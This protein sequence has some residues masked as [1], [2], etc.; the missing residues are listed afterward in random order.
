MGNPKPRI[1]VSKCL[2][3]ASC[4]YNGQTVPSAII[5]KLGRHVQ[6]IPVCPEVEIGLN[7]PREP[8]RIARDDSGMR[9]VGSV[10]G[11]DVTEKMLTF[12][13]NFLSSLENID[14]FILKSRSP[15]CGTKDVKVYPGPGKVGSVGK[16]AGFFGAATTARFQNLPI[17]DEGR[18][19]NF[20]IREHFLTR[21]F[22]RARF[23]EV[24]ENPSMVALVDFQ[25]R[26][27][28]LL[29]A[30]SPA[31]A[32]EL[33]RIV[34]NHDRRPPAEVAADYLRVL[35]EAFPRTARP[36]TYVNVLHHTL[37]HFSD[38][39][40]RREKAFFLSLIE[41][42]KARKIPLAVVLNQL[43]S[44]AVRF[45]D[46]YLQRQALFEPCPADLLAVMDSGKGR[47]ID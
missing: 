6:F 45:E 39:L 32:S 43:Q 30:Y 15:S 26:H 22:T 36:G 47:P 13:T 46:E 28:L 11:A 19:R 14:G 33:G 8:I 21:I 27:K 7:V 37:G 12:A 23:R 16:T 20:E 38:V 40:S 3:F 34:A 31:K 9:L 1:V 35:D 2:G 5:E 29:N 10:N 17:E 44:W 18:L 41:R 4:R 24:L 42:Y 25:G